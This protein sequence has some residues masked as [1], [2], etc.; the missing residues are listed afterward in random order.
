MH[1]ERFYLSA[2]RVCGADIYSARGNKLYCTDC[3]EKHMQDRKEYFRKYRIKRK[4]EKERAQ[5][6]KEN[7]YNA[8][9]LQECVRAARMLG[10]SYGHFMAAKSE[11]QKT[12]TKGKKKA[13]AAE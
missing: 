5:K 2:C 9:G 3:M 4:R 11:Y 1:K 13:E 8:V 7:A 10:L 6:A 12:M